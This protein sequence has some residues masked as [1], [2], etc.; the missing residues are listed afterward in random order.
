MALILVKILIKLII[1]FN[2]TSCLNELLISYFLNY[3]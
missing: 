1:F 2:I 3:H